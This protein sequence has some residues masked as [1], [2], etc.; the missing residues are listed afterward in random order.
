MCGRYVLARQKG[1]L[2]AGAELTEDWANFNIAPS[3]VVPVVVDH[4]QDGGFR[5][6]IHSARWGLLPRWA[7]DEKF[8]WKTFNARSETA[9][10][11]PTFRHAMASQH[12]AVPASGYYEWRTRTAEGKKPVKTPYFVH[13]Q[14]PEEMIYFAG[15][16]D[17]WKIPEGPDAGQWL[18]SVSILTMASPSGVDAA[19]AEQGGEVL[20]D[21]GQLHDR[22]PV[23]LRCATDEQD[24]LSDWLRSVQDRQQA[25][26]ALERARSAAYGIAA[27]WELREVGPAVGKVSHNGPELIE[28]ASGI[29]F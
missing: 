29:L 28:P 12:C 10:Q 20:E 7:Q 16:Y 1:D 26:A 4:E 5:R 6:E 2:V 17:W 27:G 9:A 3:T 24:G 11:K 18:L 25:A 14:D 15:L 21:L 13:P 22:L 19:V 8:S 23:P